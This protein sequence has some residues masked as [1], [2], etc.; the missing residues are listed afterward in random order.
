[1]FTA[2]PL[3]LG[4]HVVVQ[5]LAT[6]PMFQ[7]CLGLGLTS[8]DPATLTT[9]DLPDDSNFLLDRPEYWVI[10]RDFARNLNRGDEISFCVAPN[11]EVQISRNGGPP[12]VVIHV[13]QTLR[14]WAFFD[15]Y[16]STQRIRVSSY[17]GPVSPLRA[18]PIDQHNHHHRLITPSSSASESMNSINSQSEMRR[19]S[20]LQ[21]AAAAASA[22]GNSRLCGVVP[23][24]IQ[25]Q[26]SANGGAVLSVILPPPII[27]Q[28]P[29]AA[30]PVTTSVV[31]AAAHHQNSVHG[32]NGHGGGYPNGGPGYSGSAGGH[33]VS[34][35]PLAITPTTANMTN[36]M[37][38]NTYIEVSLLLKKNVFLLINHIV[39]EIRNYTVH[40]I[41]DDFLALLVETN[42][43]QTKPW[44]LFDIFC[45]L[46]RFRLD[47]VSFDI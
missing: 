19:N 26:P 16:G 35:L 37:M 29:T 40:I 14:L 8:C 7:G 4:E 45:Q 24:D 20:V 46:K 28:S 10:S 31:A 11:G 32:Q 13:D 12:S 23:A 2:R 15:V 27:G 34:P 30:I 43:K 17:S 38:S 44:R 3:Q 22:G 9:S 36:T 33:V 47:R 39:F 5:I 18:V 1:M 41:C 25:V 42:F 6:E 21:A